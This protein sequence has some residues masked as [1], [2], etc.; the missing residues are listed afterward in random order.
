MQIKI[1]HLSDIHFM[2]GGEEKKPAFKPFI[3][4][5]ETEL[6]SDIPTY[7]VLSGDIAYAGD[8][9]AH[10]DGL[11]EKLGP[12][13]DRVGIAKQRRICVPGNHDVSTDVVE[14]HILEHEP[15]VGAGFS[16]C[17]YNDFLAKPADLFREKFQNY[18]NFQEKF[19]AYGVSK[20]SAG[21]LGHSLPEGVG[22]YCANTAFFSS[23]AAKSGGTRI[24]DKGRLGIP[25]RSI[26]AWLD[27][28]ANSVKVLVSHHPTCW[29]N[30]WSKE[31]IRRISKRFFLILNGHL[32]NQD[33]FHSIEYGSNVVQLAAPALLTDK[34]VPMGYAVVT[35]CTERGAISVKYRQWSNKSKFVL[36]TLMA[37]ND[38]GVV[39]FLSVKKVSDHEISDSVMFRFFD[40]GLQRALQAFGRQS[41]PWVEPVVR[42]ASETDRQRD[43]AS[44]VGLQ[45]I[46]KSSASMFIKA[47]PQYGLSCL[48]WMLCREA[49]ASSNEKVWL[50][51]DLAV[52]K[53]HKVRDDLKAQLRTFGRESDGV[54]CIVVDSWASSMH[55][56]LKCLD[57][58]AKEYPGIRLIVL[59]TDD[60]PMVDA[61]SSS[62][63]GRTFEQLYL[64]ALPRSGL[65]QVVRNYYEAKGED[66]ANLEHVLT[67]VISD[68][69][70]LNLP[71]TALNCLT[72]L[73]VS[74]LEYDDSPINR[75]EVIKRILFLIF[76]S[77]ISLTYRSRADVKD[78]EHL[79]GYFAEK[80]VKDGESVFTREQF[81]AMGSKFCKI[82]LVDLDVKGVLSILIESGVI[83]DEDGYLR[84]RFS[85]WVYYFAALRMHHDE[86][87]ANYILSDMQYTRFP[88]VIEFYTGFDRRREDAIERL[89][90]D[91]TALCDK[92]EA[93]CGLATPAELYAAARWNPSDSEIERIRLDIEEQVNGSSLPLEI[94]DQFA[95]RTYDPAKPYNQAVQNV[96]R[97]YSFNSLTTGVSAASRALRNSDY[98]NPEK[99]K[100]LLSSIMRCWEQIQT[101]LVLISPSLANTG[102]ASFDGTDFVLSDHFD[103]ERGDHVV[104]KIWGVVPY[105]ILSWFKGDIGSAKMGP[106]LYSMLSSERVALTRHN[107]ATLVIAI[108]PKGW[109]KIIEDYIASVDK[110][111]FFL[112]DSHLALDCEYRYSVLTD[113]AKGDVGD[114]L[115]MAF[116]KHDKGS[117]RPSSKLIGRYKIEENKGD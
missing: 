12:A 113:R 99:K 83:V 4:D 27:R 108:R 60:R 50:R 112:M 93:K 68:L 72:L 48:G 100:R 59:E 103:E 78:C 92:I 7:L 70:V 94:K 43:K 91:L 89:D 19:A 23:G 75:A 10:Y 28:Q 47:P 101:V 6:K 109:R 56:S 57:A 79:L 5:L 53:P 105:N 14:R 97:A 44:T 66:D 45:D 9:V 87:F 110:N 64:W 36:G 96:M 80:I 20:E 81:V 98:V 88:E 114:L 42:N 106:L 52:T 46:V 33:V 115:K 49:V 39:D 16:E 3:S 1:L 104:G 25:T 111:S 62:V 17:E 15:I 54:S 73:M 116:A 84:F 35:V 11:L 51:V 13:L 90:S 58:I 40:S 2:P 21:G 30:E 31:E 65:R 61:I 117:K 41:G 82:M 26:A 8:Q 24:S 32:H 76:S 55:N 86:E 22:I 37:D 34:R 29:F 63:A 69:G 71:R 74:E 18:L 107:L 95:D 67:K 38:A 102:R 85:Y 77:D